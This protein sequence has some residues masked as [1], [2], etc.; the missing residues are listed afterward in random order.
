MNASPNMPERWAARK[1]MTTTGAQTL[2]E[3]SSFI[4]NSAYQVADAGQQVIS[5]PGIYTPE[6]PYVP[7]LG[8]PKSF[9]NGG[10]EGTLPPGS[11]V[12]T[13]DLWD[14]IKDVLGGGGGS[15]LPGAILPPLLQQILLPPGEQPTAGPEYTPQQPLVGAGD[16]TQANAQGG[17]AGSMAGVAG[18]LLTSKDTFGYGRTMLA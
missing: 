2:G 4:N 3:S 11:T 15:P 1:G 7:D 17:A 12:P 5:E 16:F 10:T 6:K 13:K 14:V 18:T 8:D 9:I